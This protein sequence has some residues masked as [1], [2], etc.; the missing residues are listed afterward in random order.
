MKFFLD[1]NLPPSWAEALNAL[2]GTE[3]HSV[4]HLRTKFP[5]N[6]TDVEWINTL[7][8][9]GGWTIISGD[10]RISRNQHERQA[11]LK[12]GMVAFFLTKGWRSLKFWDQT[13]RIVRW[14]PNILQQSELVIAPAGFEVPDNY[15]SGKFRPINLK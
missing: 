8:S 14:W 3:K 4:H 7:A 12:S 11:W 10:L 2:S 6:V 5:R 13:W 9:E 15:G 1:N